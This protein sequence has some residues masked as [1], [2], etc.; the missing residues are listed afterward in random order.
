MRPS[1]REM[2]E[3]IRYHWFRSLL[4]LLAIVAAFYVLFHY[5]LISDETRIE[6][7]IRA[8]AQAAYNKSVNGVV[9]YLAPEYVDV[10]LKADIKEIRLLLAQFFMEFRE[11]HPAIKQLRIEVKGDKARAQVAAAVYVSPKDEPGKL[12][13]LFTGDADKGFFDLELEKRDGQWLIV[14]ARRPKLSVE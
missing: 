1:P 3:I 6:R 4:L 13:A 9:K 12:Y 10:E 8:T 7:L 5:V 14:T 11:V 2:W